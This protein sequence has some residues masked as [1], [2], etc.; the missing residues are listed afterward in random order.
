MLLFKFT[1]DQPVAL[2]PGVTDAKVAF[3]AAYVD[4][5]INDNITASFV[6]AFADPQKA[7]EQ[8]FGRTKHF[9]HGMVFIAHRY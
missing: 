6:A 5:S 3:E 7:V 8:A 2:A 4:W 1:P 9:A